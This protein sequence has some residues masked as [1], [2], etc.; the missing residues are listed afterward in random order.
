MSFPKRIKELCSPA[1]FYLAGAGVGQLGII[2]LDNVEESNLH[3]QII[4]T[5]QRIGVNKVQAK[6]IKDINE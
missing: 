5:E 6:I 3:R 4:H 1:A 2:D